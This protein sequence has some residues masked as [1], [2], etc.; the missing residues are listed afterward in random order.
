MTEADVDREVGLTV[1][2]YSDNEKAISCLEKH[3]IRFANA[4][5][6]YIEDDAK[7]EIDDVPT[8]I[9]AAPDPREEFQE[10]LRRYEKRG[11]CLRF[12]ERQGLHLP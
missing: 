12:L 4:L 7:V 11:E 1:R 5:K 2:E 3:L 6:Q 10:L 8:T 9:A